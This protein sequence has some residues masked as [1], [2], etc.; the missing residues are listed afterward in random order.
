VRDRW[1]IESWH[2]IRDVPLHEDKHR[3]KGN[4]AGVMG[5]LRTAGMNLLR[6]DDFKSLRAAMQAVIHNISVL[7][8]RRPATTQWNGSTMA[9]PGYRAGQGFQAPSSGPELGLNM[10]D[11]TV[12]MALRKPGT[13]TGCHCESAPGSGLILARREG[14]GRSAGAKPLLATTAMLMPTHGDR[15]A[16]DWRDRHLRSGPDPLVTYD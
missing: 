10:R 15:V 3:Y 9:A 2:W 7:L 14:C 1:S 11:S 6:F 16:H 5:W 8:V 13:E 12:V 4:G